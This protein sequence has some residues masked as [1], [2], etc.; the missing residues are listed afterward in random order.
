MVFVDVKHHVYVD[1]KQQKLA[2]SLLVWGRE[3]RKLSYVTTRI[4]ARCIHGPIYIY[5]C[6]CVC[7]CPFCI[8]VCKHETLAHCHGLLH[9]QIVFISWDSDGGRHLVVTPAND[10][11][12]LCP[13]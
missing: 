9:P 4:L 3:R 2:H 11:D 12:D 6:V 13:C 10:S 8:L 5:I 7:V 1:V